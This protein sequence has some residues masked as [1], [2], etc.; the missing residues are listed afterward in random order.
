MTTRDMDLRPR[1]LEQVRIL[2]RDGDHVD[3]R[4]ESAQH[5]LRNLG[6][7]VVRVERLGRVPGPRDGPLVVQRVA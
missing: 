4:E 7:T 5:I 6:A 3:V 1:E 2:F